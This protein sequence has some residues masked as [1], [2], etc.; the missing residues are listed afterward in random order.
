MRVQNIILVFDAFLGMGEG[1]DKPGAPTCQGGG[2]RT[3]VD[4]VTEAGTKVQLIAELL[5]RRGSQGARARWRIRATFSHR[6]I[7]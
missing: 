1:R 6:T 7:R 5:P 4:P 3:E 2:V